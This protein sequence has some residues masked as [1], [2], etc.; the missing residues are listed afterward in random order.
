M[1]LGSKCV[2]WGWGLPPGGWLGKQVV[3][4][5]SVSGGHGSL[6]VKVEAPNGAGSVTGVWQECGVLGTQGREINKYLR[7]KGLGY[8]SGVSGSGFQNS[9]QME[10]LIL[11]T[12]KLEVSVPELS[13]S[14]AYGWMSKA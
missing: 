10:A 6:I 12:G 1:A 5:V 8:W 13:F 2:V 7:A 14:K 3:Y 4:E 11:H 9:I